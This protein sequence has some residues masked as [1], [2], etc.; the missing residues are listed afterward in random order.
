M[1]HN[2]T[3]MGQK[4]DNQI[5]CFDELK[6]ET[7]DKLEEVKDALPEVV[8]KSQVL[9][10]FNEIKYLIKHQKTTDGANCGATGNPGKPGDC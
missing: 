8:D 1:E 4:M 10:N 9:D 3:S 2:L 5:S 7:L 6:T